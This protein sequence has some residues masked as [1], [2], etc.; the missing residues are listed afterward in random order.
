M[1]QLLNPTHTIM[2]FLPSMLMGT[3]TAQLP[4]GSPAALKPGAKKT[5]AG[6]PGGLGGAYTQSSD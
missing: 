1:A 5:Q 6:N 3:A 4:A 2:L